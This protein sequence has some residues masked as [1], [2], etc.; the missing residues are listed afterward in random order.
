MELLRVI[1]LI[2][3]L[4]YSK[5]YHMLNHLLEISD[6][7][8]LFHLTSGKE[9]DLLKNFHWYIL[10]QMIGHFMPK[11]LEGH[12]IWQ[13]VKFAY[14]WYLDKSTEFIRKRRFW[15]CFCFIQL[16][17]R[18]FWIFITSTSWKWR[19]Y[20]LWSWRRRNHQIQNL[21]HSKHDLIEKSG[22]YGLYMTS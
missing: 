8:D 17:N 13:V 22:N 12:L 18:R 7:E 14:I 16:Q 9:L 6:G 19:K 3:E 2:Q 1:F 21:N 20:G 10:K 4:L 11:N 5:E 15:K